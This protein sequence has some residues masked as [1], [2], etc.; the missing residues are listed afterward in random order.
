[1]LVTLLLQIL[2]SATL[3]A[4]SANMEPRSDTR[5]SL[6]QNT[7]Y[8]ITIGRWDAP[9]T[10]C[11]TPDGQNVVMLK[12]QPFQGR[13]SPPSL[14]RRSLSKDSVGGGDHSRAYP[15]LLRITALPQAPYPQAGCWRA[16]IVC[17]RSRNRFQSDFAPSLMTTSVGRYAR[18][19]S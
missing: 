16:Q 2:G 5:T 14:P 4:K 12:I 10:V 7:P 18:Y 3:R 17:R 1:M 6:T 9:R 19:P 11:G 13:S 15:A 8:I